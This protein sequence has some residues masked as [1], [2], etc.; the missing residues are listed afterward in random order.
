M[1]F[2]LYYILDTLDTKEQKI[3]AT[4]IC[5][6]FDRLM[7][8]VALKILRSEVD[9][10]DAVVQTVIHICENIDRFMGKSDADL[11]RMVG[12]YAKNAAINIYN[13]NKRVQEHKT[14]LTDDEIGDDGIS[15][16]VFDFITEPE[17][18]GVLQQYV[19]ALDDF[20]KQLLLYRFVEDMTCEDIAKLVDM[21]SST[22]STKINRA[23][24][25]IR[26]RYLEDQAKEG[27][28]K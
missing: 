8:S 13:K 26:K 20:T 24:Q 27:T 1:M 14:I 22:V 5:D 4:Y 2:N 23:I 3:T 12:R 7:Y 11:K 15:Q 19:M 9:A 25:K 18:Y 16:D 21:S 6:R 28:H 10:E 17:H